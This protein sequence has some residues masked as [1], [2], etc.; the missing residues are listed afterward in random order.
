MQGAC[1]QLFLVRKLGRFVEA[2]GTN[3]DHWTKR[4]GHN[5]WYHVP[6]LVE[7]T[8]IKPVNQTR[9]LQPLISGFTFGWKGWNKAC[10]PNAMAAALDIRIHFWLRRQRWSHWTKHNGHNPWYHVPLLVEVLD[11]LDS[12]PSKPQFVCQTNCEKNNNLLCYNKTGDDEPT[13]IYRRSYSN[14]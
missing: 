7:K 1:F 4:D 11:K 13:I 9:W 6:L 5:P 3:P 12:R 8:E 14:D 10:E 2:L